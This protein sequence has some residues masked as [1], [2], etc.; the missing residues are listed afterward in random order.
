MRS[1]VPVSTSNKRNPSQGGLLLLQ[2]SQQVDIVFQR[3]DMPRMEPIETDKVQIATPCPRDHNPHPPMV[4]LSFSAKDSV[5]LPNTNRDTPVPTLSPNFGW[6]PDRVP[7]PCFREDALSLTVTTTAA[8][9]LNQENLTLE[10]I[11]LLEEFARPSNI[12][13]NNIQ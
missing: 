8:V 2:Q 9:F 1:Q 6:L 4:V 5:L 13:S 7:A 10:L 3:I 12:E 11:S